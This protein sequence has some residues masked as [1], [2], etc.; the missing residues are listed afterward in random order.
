MVCQVLYGVSA[1]TLPLTRRS[2][3]DRGEPSRWLVQSCVEERGGGPRKSGFAVECGAFLLQG[4]VGHWWRD[5]CA[6]G[7]RGRPVG[8]CGFFRDASMVDLRQGRDACA[9]ADKEHPCRGCCFRRGQAA[10]G[11]EAPCRQCSRAGLRMGHADG[12]LCSPVGG[13]LARLPL[14]MPC[15]PRRKPVN[16]GR[17]PNPLCHVVRPGSSSVVAS[18]SPCLH[19]PFAH[20]F[21]LNSLHLPSLHWI[22][23]SRRR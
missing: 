16:Q 23:S 4:V 19:P 7:P 11:G 5:G 2:I 3:D 20:K 8:W 18:Y 9:L 10:V 6:V 21:L 17:H 15:T 13:Y 1:R 22:R 12:H 14:L